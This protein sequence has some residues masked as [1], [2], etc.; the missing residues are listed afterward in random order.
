VIL[1][2]SGEM[3]T[4]D[5]GGNAGWGD[6]PQNSPAG[7]CTNAQREPGGSDRDGLHHI[8]GA[9]YYGGHPNPTRA[10]KANTFGGQTPIDIAANP[11]ECEY[12]SPGLADG[13]G[14]TA[15]TLVTF[16]TSTNGLAEYTASNFGG[17][18]QGDL[19]TA[20]LDN[21]IY[22]IAMSSPSAATKSSLVSSAG[23]GGGPLD[24]T[25]L[26]D[27]GPFPGTIWYGDL[28]EPGESVYVL[29]PTDYDG[30]TATCDLANNDADGDGFSNGDETANGTDPCSPADFPPDAD[31]DDVSD[32][33]DTDD[34]NDSI[35]DVDDAFARDA[36]NGLSTTMPV[37]YQWENDS[38]SPGGLLNLGFTGLMRAPDGS[39]YLD[40]FDRSKM[41]TGGAAG[42][43]TV[44]EVDEG[45]AYELANTQHYGFQFGV[46]ARPADG[47]FLV[48]SRIEAPFAGLTPTDYQSMGVFIGTGDQDDY[49]KLV[50]G[51]N[52][53]NRVEALPE[54]ADDARFDL[55]GTV[56]Q[57]LPGPAWI[58]LYLAV[59]PVAK[60]VQP[61]FTSTTAGVPTSR[62]DVGPAITVPD[63][64]FTAAGRGLAVGIISTSNG[65]GQAFPA[66]WDFLKVTRDAAP[67]VDE[68]PAAPTGLSA[69][70]GNN[71]VELNWN[72]NGESD[73]AGYRV[74]RASG[75]GA[76]AQ[77]HQGPTSSFVDTGAGNGTPYTYTVKA[78][79]DAG[80]E[81]AASAAVQAT[82]RAPVV[83][84]PTPTPEPTSTATPQPTPTATATPEPT[85]QPPAAQKLTV[86]VKAAKL[87]RALKKG[88]ALEVACPAA[89]R[90][91]ARLQLE[92]KAARTLRLGRKATYV[93][94]GTLRATTA[95]KRTLRVKFTRAAKRK[96]AKLRRVDLVLVLTA[97]EGGKR[98]KS[99]RKVRLRR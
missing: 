79:D 91:T 35:A 63:S 77:I 5:N 66:S 22:R 47:S 93:A 23:A 34:D 92:A 38:P 49:V 98:T 70:P 86:K 61:S 57:T 30:G 27:D 36:N 68:P 58:D 94:R 78:Y 40:Q 39:D 59:D 45:D 14:N 16:P 12:R 82:P 44:D 33:T 20:G 84:T 50:V 2:A 60:K 4:I 29:E 37:D 48:H 74:F 51:R 43:V 24:I 25:T 54:F 99:T 6:F 8:T 52:G 85:V 15:G 1:T 95:G 41:T 67:P 72:D 80:H 88:L 10:N 17:A 73:L 9:G 11:V 13:S 19:V 26:G 87:R 76:P 21:V 96:L 69:D 81:S 56:A 71:R 31:G 90:L 65:P 75:G 89:C 55:G 7:T 83:T 97:D 62:R 53:A 64:W 42:V 3:Y 18:M 46:K 28:F 32:K